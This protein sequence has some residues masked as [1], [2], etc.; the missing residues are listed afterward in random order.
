VQRSGWSY[1]GI[2]LYFSLYDKNKRRMKEHH[3]VIGDIHGCHTELLKLLRS[4][5]QHAKKHQAEITIISVGDLID[6]GPESAL[7]VEELLLRPKHKTFTVMGN[8]ESILLELLHEFAPANFNE[9][10]FPD[11]LETMR[12]HFIRTYPEGS[13]EEFSLYREQC[14]ILWLQQGG[15][16]ALRSYGLDPKS[17]GQW[18]L[19]SSHIHE[20]T[21]LPLLFEAPHFLVTH[22]LASKRDVENVVSDEVSD[23]T[24]FEAASKVM[25][26]R[27]ERGLDPAHKILH[28]SGHTPLNGIKWRHKKRVLQLDTGCYL[29]NMMSAYC[30]ETHSFLR[31]HALKRYY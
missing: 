21:D 1:C 9:N 4:I 16:M 15:D 8:H 2:P 27:D 14:L 30:V 6:R 29:G 20:L 3:Y 19:P 23:A 25:W 10:P 7:I 26:N 18:Q 13:E 12:E 11:T 24:Y 22:A 31:S 17:P 28:I 5:E